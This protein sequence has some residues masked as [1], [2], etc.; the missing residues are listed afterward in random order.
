V[1]LRE[2]FSASDF[3]DDIVEWNCTLFQY[4]G[5]LCRYLVNSPPHPRE[6]E[7]RIRLCCGNGLRAEVWEDFKRRFRIPQILEFYA[8]TE[9]NVSLYNCEGKP[10]AI[11]R[12][13][14]FLAHRF[15]V[16]LIKC[17]IETGEPVR[18]AEGFCIRCSVNQVG[19][20]VGKIPEDSSSPGSRFE[21]YTDEEASDRKILR[22]V[23]VKGD[24][25]FRTGDLMRKDAGGYFYF[26]DRVGDTFRWK[27]E[28]V[29]TTEVAEAISGC[30]R[31]LEAVVYGVTMPG[32]EG[33]AGMAAVVVSQDFDLIAFRQ[34]LAQRLPEYARP[35][36]LRIRGEVETTSTF[37]PK[38]RDLMREG[39]DPA[40]IADTLYFND[41]VRQAFVELDAALY[42][43]SRARDVRL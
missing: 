41:H 22:N 18:N 27:G 36:F 37:K 23:F 25:W 16:A 33:R 32:A 42:E 17:D 19:E 1:V 11:G 6:A 4:I 9:S 29:S 13:P 21:G 43:R 31:V 8:A 35:L 26:V 15:H 20:A 24:A 28:N 3:W 30:P 2:R 39:Y 7:H 12:I 40:I 10:G 38:K 14:S 5:E 34:H